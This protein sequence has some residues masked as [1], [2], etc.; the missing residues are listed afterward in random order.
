MTP[1]MGH[2]SFLS[3]CMSPCQ[4]IWLYTRL[5]DGIHSQIKSSGTH[6][7]YLRTKRSSLVI[8]VRLE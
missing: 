8:T 3:G 6:G 4:P 7:T 2:I 5:T 1:N